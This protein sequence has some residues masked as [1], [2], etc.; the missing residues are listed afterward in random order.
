M[1]GPTV[2]DDYTP[3]MAEVREDFAAYGALADADY[4][5]REAMFDRAIAAHDAELRAETLREAARDYAYVFA[6]TSYKSPVWKWLNERAE[7]AATIA[8]GTS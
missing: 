5:R 3:S 1:W 7:R 4:R 6:V 8:E 2:A